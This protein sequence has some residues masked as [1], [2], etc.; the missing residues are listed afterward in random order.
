MALT[1]GPLP[2]WVASRLKPIEVYYHGMN[3]VIVV[4][5]DSHTEVGYYVVPAPSSYMPGW[6]DHGWSWSPQAIPGYP[7]SLYVYRRER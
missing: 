4:R 7:N 5:R 2:D 1:R 3:L 6:P